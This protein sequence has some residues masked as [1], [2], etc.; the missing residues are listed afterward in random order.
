VAR[1]KWA[2]L[3]REAKAADLEY[4]IT[5]YVV[6]LLFPA[7]IGVG[8]A[9]TGDMGKLHPFIPFAFW[10]VLLGIYALLWWRVRPANRS[11]IGL[12]RDSER[13]SYELSQR[14]NDVDQLGQSLDLLIWQSEIS[15][16]TR[17]MVVAYVEQGVTDI[18]SLRECLGELLAPVYQSAEELFGTGASERWSVAVYLY[19]KKQDE[20]IPI[21][22]ER[23]QLHPSTGNGRNWARGEGHVGKAF[24]NGSAIITLDA[25]HPDVAALSATPPGKTKSYDDVYRSFAAVP[26][27][28]LVGEG[29]PLG[30]L[31]ATSDRSGRYDQ[32]N[33]NVL[34]HLADVIAGLVTLA[35]IDVDVLQEHESPNSQGAEGE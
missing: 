25:S 24:V 12:L 28:P 14:K 29:L 20:L 30:V 16:S 4:A 26:I 5:N 13:L 34:R 17:R 22:T 23:A 7:L 33:T 8:G 19:S 9:Y 2:I 6:G 3:S 1:S 15:L 35:H 21:W 32:E 11:I 10:L 27:G 31:V 18:N